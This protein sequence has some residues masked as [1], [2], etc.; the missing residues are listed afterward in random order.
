[1]GKRIQ[2]IGD[3]E[4]V[5]HLIKGEHWSN[6]LC[7]LIS[8]EVDVDRLDYLMRDAASA[9]VGYGNY[10]LDWLIN[11]FSLHLDE[12]RRPRLLL[13]VHRGL[14]AV[15]QFSSARRSMYQQVYYHATVRGAGRLLRAVFER[16]SDPARQDDYKAN[17][18]E[19]IPECLHSFLQGN[20]PTLG[21]FLSTDDST[22]VTALKRWSGSAED[23]VLRYLAKCFLE[24]R[25]YKEIQVGA[26]DWERSYGLVKDETRAALGRQKSADLPSVG[27]GDTHDLDY[28]VLAD[29]CEFKA[30]T[31]FEGVLFD[32][33]DSAP[34]AFENV[35]QTAG[36]ELVKGRRSFS[37]KRLF[38]ASEVF[39]SV[40]DALRGME[41]Q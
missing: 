28:F 10:D 24:R 18:K 31:S 32:V 39:S 29:N 15:E 2:K 34:M 35:E 40:Q 1:M 36:H 20:R 11:S 26:L 4:Q 7:K 17:A 23:P 5:I 25:L 14:V 38:V 12:G 9:G 3:L 16:A 22:I 30:D 27:A 13:E 8:G 21:E 19:G 33:D 41:A 6:G 37:R